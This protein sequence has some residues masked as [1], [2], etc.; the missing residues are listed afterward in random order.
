[1]IEQKSS[2]F[3]LL[4]ILGCLFA[5]LYDF[6]IQGVTFA[7]VLAILVAFFLMTKLVSI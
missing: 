4:T 5:V 7:I 3:M 2:F 6:G 1:M